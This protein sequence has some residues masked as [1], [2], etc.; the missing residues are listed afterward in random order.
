M[1]SFGTCWH[2][3]ARAEIHR[4]TLTKLWNSFNEKSA[5]VSRAYVDNDGTGKFLIT[6]VERDWMLPFSLE[7]GEFLYQLRGALDAC[8]YDTAALHFG[9]NPPPDEHQWEF[10]VAPSPAKFKESISRIKR[11]PDDVRLLMESVQPYTALT[12]TLDGNT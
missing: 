11:L 5:Y 4:Q 2:R 9:Q 12:T 7:F 3:V 1:L 10:K 6:P 8:V